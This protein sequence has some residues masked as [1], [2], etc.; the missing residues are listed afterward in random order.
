MRIERSDIL[1]QADY[2]SLR[3]EF[4][5]E[6]MALKDE[7][8]FLLGPYFCFLFENRKT[9]LYQIQELLRAES[10]TSEEKIQEQIEVYNRL[11][12]DKYEI[13][14]TLLLEFPDEVLR[15]THLQ[16]WRGLEDHVHLLLDH[17]VMIKAQFDPEQFHPE[18][19]SSVQYLNFAL[20]Q[21][22]TE[23][24]LLAREIELVVSH[25][26]C[27]DREALP[28]RIVAALRADLKSGLQ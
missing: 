24:F 4:R 13:R 26:A 2:N 9:I 8:R 19:L 14:A 27:N 11:L 12:P 21:A 1:S 15:V 5:A 10:I 20:A 16:K 23:A 18:I 28:D 25:P 17:D 3:P 6:V 22:G 7:R